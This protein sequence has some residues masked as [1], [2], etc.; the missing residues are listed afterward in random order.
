MAVS[1]GR[2]AIPLLSLA[3]VTLFIIAAY[4]YLLTSQFK[5]SQEHVVVHFRRETTTDRTIRVGRHAYIL[6]YTP[7][8]NSNNHV[9]ERWP[10]WA[11]F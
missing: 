10:F 7:I 5:H 1:V 3:C 9:R 6:L 2:C 8:V 11:H 4:V